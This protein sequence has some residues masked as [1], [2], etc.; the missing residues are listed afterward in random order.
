MTKR[1]IK[2]ES[3]ACDLETVRK[4]RGLSKTELA[5]LAGTTRFQILRLEKT[6][7]SPPLPLALKISRALN[8]KIERIWNF[9]SN[10]TAQGIYF[11]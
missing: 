2:P 9:I 11:D 5:N 6:T 7:T 1:K 3:I 10:D 4:M 8:V